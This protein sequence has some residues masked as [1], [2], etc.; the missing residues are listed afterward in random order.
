MLNSVRLTTDPYL[1]KSS[2][3][4]PQAEFL[5]ERLLRKGSSFRGLEI[6]GWGLNFDHPDFKGELIS[7]LNKAIGSYQQK[8]NLSGDL[9]P[10]D[11]KKV[12][13]RFS[14]QAGRA[15]EQTPSLAS[16]SASWLNA[17]VATFSATF[18]ESTASRELEQ[19]AGHQYQQDSISATNGRNVLDVYEKK[20]KE[21]SARKDV[22]YQ[23]I[24]K[25][26]EEQEHLNS[27]RSKVNKIVNAHSDSKPGDELSWPSFTAEEQA[28]LTKY[29]LSAGSK[30][31]SDLQNFSE[32]IGNRSKQ[33]SE[34]SQLETTDMQDAI[35]Q[36]NNVTEAISKFI[37][38]MYDTSKAFM[39]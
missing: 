3:S 10:D 29:N 14:R 27:A 32:R 4:R 30:K 34:N 31:K 36:Y 22:H 6:Q 16:D 20:L 11:E 25:L 1:V 13:R 5:A 35:N 18:S 33:L 7:S 38:K 28:L 9:T 39:S 21:A 15:L 24:K 2:E 37:Q 17:V 23:N 19:K 12:I 8:N 26:I